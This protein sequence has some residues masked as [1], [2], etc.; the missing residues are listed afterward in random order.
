MIVT[1][2]RYTITSRRP[3]CWVSQSGPIDHMRAH[4]YGY[5]VTIPGEPHPFNGN[6]LSWARDLVKRK[7]PEAKVIE[8]WRK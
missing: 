8:T 6:T 4:S 5:K 2:D 7:A 1:I 3:G